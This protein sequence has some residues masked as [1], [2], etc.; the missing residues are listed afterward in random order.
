[1]IFFGSKEVCD[2]QIGGEIVMCPQ[3]DNV[4]PYW[5]LNTTCESSKVSQTYTNTQPLLRRTLGFDV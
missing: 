5:R 1:M 2:P 3:C 4:C